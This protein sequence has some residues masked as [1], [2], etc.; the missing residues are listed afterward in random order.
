[1]TISALP[2]FRLA[3]AIQRFL[4]LSLVAAATAHAADDHG[5]SAAGWW[6]KAW[7]IRKPVNLTPASGAEPAGANLVL[8][9]LHAGN[10]QFGAA[11]E[12]GSDVRIIAEDGK[13][14]LPLHFER[15]DALMNEALLWVLIPEIKAGAT[16]H[17][18]L[19]Y[20]NP[21][22]PASTISAKDSFPSTASLIYHFTDRGAPARDSSVNGNSSTTAPAVT[23]GALIAGGILQFGTNGIDVP[24]SD[25]LK[26]GAAAEVTISAWVKPTA[27]AAGGA[28]FKR[29]D[30]GSSFV[31]GVD[32]GIPYVEIKDGSGTARTAPGEAIAV[33]G[34]KHLAVVASTTKTDLYVGG[35]PYGSI[36]KPMPALA[37]PGTIGGS[38]D[39]GGGFTGEVDEFQIHNAALTAGTINF[40]AIAESGSDEA[41]K[42]VEVLEDEGSGGTSHRPEW[43]EHILLF[44]DIAEKMKFDGWVAVALCAVMIVL[45]WWIS[46]VKFL[47]LNSIQKGSDMFLKEWRKLSAS[48]H[49]LDIHD[50]EGLQT[51]GGN[52][53]RAALHQIKKSPIYHLYL[54]GFE[55]IRHRANGSGRPTLSARSMQAIKSALDSGLVHESHN[56]TGGLILL[57]ISVAGGP[58]IGLLGTV[59]GVMIT[60]AEIAKTG[61]V[62]VA[63]IAPGIASALLA[64]T[65]GL[66]VAIPALFNYS[67]LNTRIKVLLSS[68]T[69][70][71]DEFITKSAEIFPEQPDSSLPPAPPAPLPPA[72]PVAPSM[73]S[74]P[75]SFGPGVTPGPAPAAPAE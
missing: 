49:K 48:L 73:P 54:I 51:L 14:E 40:H 72:S 36:P 46:I 7:A 38:I 26:W 60:F 11:K 32:S 28:L 75:V 71:I 6:D 9:R 66:I 53:S 5:G 2:T 12:D 19:Y 20:G 41:L 3:R 37:T 1:M 63:A 25:S 27:Q 52:V 45:S 39:A 22:A 23:E 10:F 56:M 16:T 65:V 61:E 44:G 62:E 50:E 47:Y 68:M 31:L 55:E 43:V 69:V 74:R 17:L 18:H 67:Y 21:E 4:L 64:T 29:V 24:G 13:T 57:T 30:G 34:W 58:Y 33:G 42:M 8:L 59:V 15:Y 70:F 35:K